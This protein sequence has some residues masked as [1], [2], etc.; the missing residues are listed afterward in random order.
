MECQFK[1]LLN[2]ASSNS[3]CWQGKLGADK[4]H[5]FQ[6]D[7]LKISWK[8]W[9]KMHEKKNFHLTWGTVIIMKSKITRKL[10]LLFY[11]QKK[12]MK[13]KN[14]QKLHLKLFSV[15][16]TRKQKKIFSIPFHVYHVLNQ[17]INKFFALDLCFLFVCI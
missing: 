3:F 7:S 11:K 12:T 4:L 10:I 8:W 17:K 13:K 16:Q 2:F 15:L 6:Q 5:Y 1:I 9:P 14:N